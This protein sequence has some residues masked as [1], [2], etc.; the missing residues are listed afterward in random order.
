[1]QFAFAD[2]VDLL[3]REVEMLAAV[4]DDAMRLRK[5]RGCWRLLRC[6]KNN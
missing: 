5:R 3:S 4:A 2:E 1:M 6:E